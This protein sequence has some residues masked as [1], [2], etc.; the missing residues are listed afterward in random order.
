MPKYALIQNNGVAQ[1]RDVDDPA[2]IPLHKLAPDGGLLLRQVVED[3]KPAFRWE[4]ERLETSVAIERDCVRITY[5]VVPR[6][7]GEIAAQIKAE[8]Q[9][10]I[11]ARYPDWLQA[12]MIARQG[13]LLRAVIGQMIDEVGNPLPARDLTA[14]ELQELVVINAAWS[15]IKAVR[16]ASNG[17]EQMTELPE[18]FTANEHWPD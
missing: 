18:N 6:P 4:T 10:R 9:R 11:Y 12:N 17:L 16:M 13:E 5:A 14:S 7:S 1:Y 2:A 3:E 15:W 8:A